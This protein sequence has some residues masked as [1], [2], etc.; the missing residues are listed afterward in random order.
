MND[1]ADVTLTILFFLNNVDL[2]AY[3]GNSS[4]GDGLIRLDIIHLEKHSPAESPCEESPRETLTD[5]RLRTPE[6]D[7]DRVAEQLLRLIGT[8]GQNTHFI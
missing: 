2:S 7:S 4:D 5:C 1:V 3:N 8:R 6:G